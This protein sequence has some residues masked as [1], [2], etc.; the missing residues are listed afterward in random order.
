ME[1]LKLHGTP[2]GPLNKALIRLGQPMESYGVFKTPW[3]SI[4]ARGPWK[5][6]K[7]AWRGRG[8]LEFPS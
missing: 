3:D 7:K 5:F 8:P 4:G 6:L 1:F 2:S